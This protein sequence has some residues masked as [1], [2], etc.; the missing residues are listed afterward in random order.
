MATPNHTPFIPPL[1]TP[2][3]GPT[4]EMHTIPPPDTPP[5]AREQQQRT[6]GSFPIFPPYGTP[7]VNPPMIPPGS[8]FPPPQN[9]PPVHGPGQ[10]SADFMGYPMAGGMGF[11]PQAPYPGPTTGYM[12]PQNLPP[13]GMGGM[14]GGPTP[15][16][17]PAPA[18]YPHTPSFG[19]MGMPGAYPPAP[20][21]PMG[22]YTPAP[23]SH[24]R[25]GDN[26]PTEQGADL[27][28][29]SKWLAGPHCMSPVSLRS[30][31]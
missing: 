2:L 12:A 15:G 28:I 9:L 27:D 25:P 4:P 1:G 30:T 10:F 3:A 18:P 13:F 6:P 31:T 14:G 11:G 22:A 7:Y 21:P 8:Y 5:W 23:Q 17:G 29:Q 24:S 20:Y 16:W 19:M 26:R